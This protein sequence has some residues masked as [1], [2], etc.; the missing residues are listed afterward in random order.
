MS[1]G[2]TTPQFRSK[3]IYSPY[4]SM[5]HPHVVKSSRAEDYCFNENRQFCDI[6]SDLWDMVV[7][8]VA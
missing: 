7:S 8:N 3:R 4:Y 6:N 5:Y 2:K 1:P